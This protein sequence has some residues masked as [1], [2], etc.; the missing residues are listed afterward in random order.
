MIIKYVSTFTIVGNIRLLLMIAVKLCMLIR[1]IDSL[2]DGNNV[3][4]QNCSE[5]N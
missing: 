1:F 4:L 2:D 5:A 3:P